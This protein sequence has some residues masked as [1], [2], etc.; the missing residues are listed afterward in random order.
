MDTRRSLSGPRAW[1]YAGVS[2]ILAVAVQMCNTTIRRIVHATAGGE[3]PSLQ[4]GHAVATRAEASLMN[5]G[6]INRAG[7][8]ALRSDS[9]RSATTSRTAQLFALAEQRDMSGLEAAI[10]GIPA[11]A[12]PPAGAAP[13]H[14]PAVP[15]LSTPPEQPKVPRLDVLEADVVVLISALCRL[16]ARLPADPVS[17]GARYVMAGKHLAADILLQVV[18]SKENPWASIGAATWATLRQ[19]LCMATLRLAALSATDV[20][21]AAP[22]LFV[23]LLVRTPLRLSLKAEMGAFFPLLLLKPLE[24]NEAPPAVLAASLAASATLAAHAQ[25][26]VDLF[27]NYDCDLQVPSTCPARAFSRHVC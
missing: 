22:R 18:E 27:V 19:P 14:T 12:S 20:F 13:A 8:V 24:M 3:Q 2:Y 15:D 25:L 16:A 26:M 5:G 7:Q 23:A 1:L 17:D 9:M 21:P 4:H 10:D 11:A 6:N